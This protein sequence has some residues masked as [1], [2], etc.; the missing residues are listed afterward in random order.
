MP[1]NENGAFQ[2]SSGNLAEVSASTGAG[3]TADTAA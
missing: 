1:P 2:E 3:A